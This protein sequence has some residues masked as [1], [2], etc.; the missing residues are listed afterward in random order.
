MDPKAQKFV[1]KVETVNK[2]RE[3]TEVNELR[4]IVNIFVFVI[5]EIACV[6]LLIKNVPLPY[7]I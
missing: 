4:K 7:I 1:A 6:K 5:K 3:D 2:K